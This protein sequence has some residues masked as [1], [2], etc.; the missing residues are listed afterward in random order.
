M[1]LAEHP[2]FSEQFSGKANELIDKALQLSLQADELIFT[3]GDPSDALYLILEGIVVFSKKMPDA[4]EHSISRSSSGNFFG[5]VGIFT[6]DPRALT[7]KAETAVRIAKISRE[8]LVNY[9]KNIPGPAALLIGSMVKHLRHTTSHYVNDML[10]QEKMMVVG[11]MVNT[12]IHDFKNPFTLISLSAQLLQSQ[13]DDPKTVRICENIKSQVDRMVEMANEIVEF[14]K[15]GASLRRQKVNLA[16]LVEKFRELNEPIFQN[17]NV[18][19]I[20]K[21]EP[22][23]IDGDANKL[24]RVIQNLVGNAIDAFE[25]DR[26]GKVEVMITD[27]GKDAQIIVRDNG[28][29]I[30]EHIRD[31]LFNPFVTYGKSGGS[32]LGTAIVKAIVNAHNGTIEFA[33]NNQVGTTFKILLP[34]KFCG[35]QVPV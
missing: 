26:E 2:F 35:D 32:G 3:E 12:I 11:N 23:V 5:E 8:H 20:I 22:I 14:S 10:Q 27:Q 33:T 15:G 9:L 7:A 4:D 28:K 30:P 18:K 17:K 24:M 29:G 34:K 25:E 6:G 1:Y 21:S 16:E 31:T 19:T 13:H